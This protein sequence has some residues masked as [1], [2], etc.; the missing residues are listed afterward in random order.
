MTRAQVRRSGGLLVF[1]GPDGCGKTTQVRL[2]G[3]R[4][5]RLGVPHVLV[6]E[7]GG[8][9]LGEAVRPV[10]LRGVDMHPRSEL[11]LYLAARAALVAEKILPALEEGL[12]VVADRFYLS[13]LAYQGYGRGIPIPEV[14]KAVEFATQGLR[15]DLTLLLD[16][17]PEDA[18]AR[19]SRRTPDRIERE[20]PEFHARVR[21]G[22]ERLAEGDP[23]ISRIDAS[24]GV[25][26][27][28]RS[29]L[30]VLAQRWPET[31][32]FGSG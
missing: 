21:E 26:A 1:E 18:A 4:L 11:L 7:P 10:I 3:D 9:A 16:I 2:L 24:R 31:F 28:H 20:D 5:S 32:G 19:S 25:R 12:L 6:R 13:S 17:A 14:T 23:T 15:P 30:A 8:T 29:V 22:Y 27:V